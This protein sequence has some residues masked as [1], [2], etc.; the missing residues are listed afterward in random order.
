[1]WATQMRSR[2]WFV[3]SAATNKGPPQ[4][5]ESDLTGLEAGDDDEA[6]STA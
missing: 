6:A 3:V 4:R 5:D 2:G 1:M